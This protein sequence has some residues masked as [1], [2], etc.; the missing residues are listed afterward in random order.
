M[1]LNLLMCTKYWTSSGAKMVQTCSLW[2]E[3][4]RGRG[5]DNLYLH[6]VYYVCNNNVVVVPVDWE[7]FTLKIIRKKNF[8]VVKFSRFRSICK[9]V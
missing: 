8:R 5:R 1:R 9:F 2:G 3:G 6:M 4:G 7:I